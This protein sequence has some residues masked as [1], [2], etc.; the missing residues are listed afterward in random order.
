M[1]DRPVNVSASA[2]GVYKEVLG[3]SL[4]VVVDIVDV[5]LSLFLIWNG[6]NG[7][8]VSV[9]VP[10]NRLVHEFRDGEEREG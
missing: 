3:L 9:E 8:L 5:V 2:D 7:G 10:N 1:D 4:L 6:P